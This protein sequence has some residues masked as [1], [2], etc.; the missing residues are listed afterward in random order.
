[1]SRML[2]AGIALVVSVLLAPR[3]AADGGFFVSTAELLAQE[4]QEAVIALHEDADGPLVTY[5]IAS[6][7]AGPPQEFAWVL[8]VAGPVVAGGAS[9]ELLRVHPDRALLDELQWRSEPI[10][11]TFSGGPRW[12]LLCV[13][14]AA[15]L[16]RRRP[17]R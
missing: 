14:R 6:N 17:P 9:G 10:F 8:P 7:Y 16:R 5:V 3:A 11:R 15:G 13:L 12:R 1:M 2:R 4:R